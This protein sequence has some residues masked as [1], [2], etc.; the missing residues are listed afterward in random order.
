MY[1][2]P[3]GNT[4]K[5]IKDK[6]NFSGFYT[7]VMTPNVGASKTLYNLGVPSLSMQ[8]TSSKDDKSNPDVCVA[9]AGVDL[10]KNVC[11]CPN[12][13]VNTIDCESLLVFTL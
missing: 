12:L 4:L 5:S 9:Y 10:K 3:F 2:N 1:T 8:N 11:S 7:S 13:F 6:L